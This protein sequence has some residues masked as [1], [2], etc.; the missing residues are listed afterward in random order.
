MKNNLAALAPGAT[1]RSAIV[2]NGVGMTGVESWDVDQNTFHDPDK[3]SI[4]LAMDALPAAANTAWWAS[5]AD[6][7]VEI[8][9]GFPANPDNYSTADLVSRFYGKLDTP[10]FDWVKGTISAAGRDLSAQMSDAKTSEKFR[11][12]TSSQVAEAIAKQFVLTPKVTATTTKVGTFYARDSVNLKS[13]R[14]YWDILTWLARQEGFLAYV[15]GRELHF[16]PLPDE[17][18]ADPWALEIAPPNPGYASPQA[19][20]TSIKTSRTLTVA[21]DI[22]VTVST[23]KPG[24]NKTAIKRKAVRP[25]AG[26]KGNQVQEYSYSIPGLTAEG[27]QKRA[28]QILDDLS[29]HEKHLEFDGPADE[30]LSIGDVILLKGTGTEFDQA[31]HPDHIKRSMSQSGD[32]TWSV[33]A[34]NH[35]VESEPTP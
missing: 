27:A 32:Y 11:N 31:Y 23:Y 33:S 3:C 8:F 5:Q 25:G 26:G 17:S 6:L 18:T 24:T 15:K 28:N 13:F 20:A 30:K 4:V 34:K 19:P 14:S 12:Q 29:R 9:D 21:K 2:V 35:S 22:S 1:P 7:V 16:E 10:E